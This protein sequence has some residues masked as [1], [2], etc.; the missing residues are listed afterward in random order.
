[1]GISRYL[2]S[3]SIEEIHHSLLLNYPTFKVEAETDEMIQNF[4]ALYVDTYMVNNP[5]YCKKLVVPI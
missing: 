5:S 3:M 4:K 1:M 2:L